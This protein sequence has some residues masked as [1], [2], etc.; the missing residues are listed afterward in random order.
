MYGGSLCALRGKIL[1]P[2]LGYRLTIVKTLALALP[3]LDFAANDSRVEMGEG[4]ID[5]Y[6]QE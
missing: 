4:N 2:Y 1:P 6:F 3:I 5:Y